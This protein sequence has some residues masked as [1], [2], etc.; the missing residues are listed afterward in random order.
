MSPEEVLGGG[1]DSWS[2]PETGVL[3]KLWLVGLH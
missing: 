2:A 1:A 3:L